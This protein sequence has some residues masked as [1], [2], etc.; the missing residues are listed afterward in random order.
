MNRSLIKGI[1][2]L[3]GP[4]RWSGNGWEW[5]HWILWTDLP[6][7][8]SCSC[9]GSG[10]RRHLHLLSFIIYRLLPTFSLPFSSYP[11]SV[12]TTHNIFSNFFCHYVCST[13]TP[14]TLYFI[15][16]MYTK[17]R[18]YTTIL[19]L[20]IDQTHMKIKERINRALQKER[21]LEGYQNLWGTRDWVDMAQGTWVGRRGLGWKIPPAGQL[22]CSLKVLNLCRF[23]ALLRSCLDPNSSQVS[24]SPQLSGLKFLTP[25]EAFRSLTLQLPIFMSQNSPEK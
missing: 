6:A 10:I 15:S 12:F 20:G 25:H 24:P 2:Q 4:I 1:K 14:S 21:V 19:T 18:F 8:I 13:N 22:S 11:A 9:L 7:L 17:H 5:P 16:L 3:N 23:D